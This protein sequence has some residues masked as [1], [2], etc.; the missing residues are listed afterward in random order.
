MSGMREE[1]DCL[2]WPV[3]YSSDE[4]GAGREDGAAGDGE[5]S[6]GERTSQ[7]LETQGNEGRREGGRKRWRKRNINVWELKS[8]V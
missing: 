1:E 5:E 3:K 7:C 6:T 8:N 2:Y 4:V